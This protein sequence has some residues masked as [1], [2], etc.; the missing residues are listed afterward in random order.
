MPRFKIG[1]VLGVIMFA[2]GIIFAGRYFL[3]DTS[4]EVGPSDYAGNR[5]RVHNASLASEKQNGLIISIAVAALGLTLTLINR[6][7]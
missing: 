5:V 3:M 7:K 2:A 6:T 1:I 4:V